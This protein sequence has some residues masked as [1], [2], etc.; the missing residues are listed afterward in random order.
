MPQMK[1]E[2]AA[3]AKKTNEEMRKLNEDLRKRTE[4]FKARSRFKQEQRPEYP[5]PEL[6]KRLAQEQQK[7]GDFTP[8]L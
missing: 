3:N 4:A 2:L 8:E 1:A 6:E 5:I 7:A